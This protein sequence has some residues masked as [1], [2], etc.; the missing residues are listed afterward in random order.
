MNRDV[1]TLLQLVRPFWFKQTDEPVCQMTQYLQLQRM[2]PCGF[3]PLSLMRTTWK[4]KTARASSANRASKGAFR[5]MIAQIR[6]S[7]RKT[8]DDRLGDEE[9]DELSKAQLDAMLFQGEPEVAG[10]VQGAIEDFSQGFAGVIS[11]FLRLLR[12]GR[13]PNV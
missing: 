11:R 3:P 10:I 7:L 5:E 13:T 2:V 6:K 1:M 4:S 12:N 8:G 9:S